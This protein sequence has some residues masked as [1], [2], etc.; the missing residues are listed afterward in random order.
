MSENEKAIHSLIVDY[1][2]AHTQ[3]DGCG[4]HYAA[5]DVQVR[6]RKEDLWLASMVCRGCG[7]Q[8]LVVATVNWDQAR[9]MGATADIGEEHREVLAKRGP[10][11]GDDVLDLHKFLQGFDGDMFD[12]LRRL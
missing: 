1:L 7:L 11:G 9:M 6:R 12:L 3:C 2:V 5:E 10:I 8:R 4:Q